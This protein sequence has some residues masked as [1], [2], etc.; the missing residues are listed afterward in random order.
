MES[1][2][3]EQMQ[4]QIIQSD[5]LESDQRSSPYSDIDIQNKLIEPDNKISDDL[6]VSNFQLGNIT[7]QDYYGNLHEVSFALD[8][9]EMPFE[10]G[11][12]FLQTVG[13]KI[14]RK[15]DIADVFD[16]FIFVNNNL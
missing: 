2:Q 9:L 11:G 3:M 5:M 13:K 15:L 4:E 14:F 8:C 1:E 10:K 7:P 6:A 16:G 12:W